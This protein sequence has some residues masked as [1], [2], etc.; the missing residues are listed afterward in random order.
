MDN[1]HCYDWLSDSMNTVHS[2]QRRELAATTFDNGVVSRRA[3]VVR[4]K[5]YDEARVLVVRDG[6]QLSDFLTLPYSVQST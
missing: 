5:V 2:P 1:H 4:R 6:P 3:F